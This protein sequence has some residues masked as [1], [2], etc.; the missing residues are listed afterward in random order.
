[1][2]LKTIPLSSLWKWG[3]SGESSSINLVALLESKSNRIKSMLLLTRM[4]LKGTLSSRTASRR[5]WKRRSGRILTRLRQERC[6]GTP[7]RRRAKKR[8]S[9]TQWNGS[10]TFLIPLTSG[11]KEAISTAAQDDW[12]RAKRYRLEKVLRE[13]VKPPEWI[14]R[15]DQPPP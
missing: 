7:P 11:R 9:K 14:H 2:K 12:I 10:L 1:M 3:T 8:R 15:H 5:R 6:L 13:G 4:S